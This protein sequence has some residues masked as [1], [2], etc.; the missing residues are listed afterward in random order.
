MPEPPSPARRRPASRFAAAAAVCLTLA[1]AA[2]LAPPASGA[3]QDAGRRLFQAAEAREKS[4]REALASSPPAPAPTRDAIR[5]VVAAYR[6]VVLQHPKS[7]YCDNALWLGAQLLAEA[8]SR[9][10]NNQDRTAA[11]QLL[12][13]LVREYPSSSLVPRARAEAARLR[14]LTSAPPS[15]A[16]TAAAP[17]APRSTV[18]APATAAPAV[19]SAAA[20]EP[21]LVRDVRRRATPG[22]A[23]VEVE[24]DGPVEYR[25]ERLDQP[26]RLFVDLANTRTMDALSDAAFDFESGPVK[27]LR[28]GRRPGAV[29]RV[30][31]ETAAA[32][33]CAARLVSAPYRLVIACDDPSAPLPALPAS[34]QPARAEAPP[35]AGTP[36][37][38]A[39]TQPAAAPPAATTP[40]SEAPSPVSTPPAA[41]PV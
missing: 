37:P 25:E 30:V 16:R 35:S 24:L 4:L 13:A 36:Q 38:A 19:P 1:G 40:Q 21:V 6:Q 2:A 5:Q 11:V 39:A 10:G 28:I 8:F 29:T 27:Q 15:A 17:P 34:V 31:V 33:R 22:G 41:A 18:P 14:G 32:A 20:R 9:H 7:G 12:G 3:P 23:T 26:P